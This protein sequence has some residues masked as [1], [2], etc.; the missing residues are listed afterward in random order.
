M[1][2]IKEYFKVKFFFKE[3]FDCDK[4]ERV[5]FVYADSL[6][7]IWFQL[8]RIGDVLIELMDQIVNDVL[9]IFMYNFQLV[10]ILFCFGK[11]IDNDMWY[12]V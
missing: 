12:R 2:I 3:S 8:E 11:F 5:Y 6:D 9:G 1:F 10:V 4:R 7:C